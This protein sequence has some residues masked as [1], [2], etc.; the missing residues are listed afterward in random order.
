MPFVQP[1][2]RQVP[3]R[4][5]DRAAVG[6]VGDGAVVDL[7]DADL[8]E[9][10]D[11]GDGGLDVRGEPVEVFLEEL[12]FALLVGAV[13]VAAGRALLV[14][15]EDETAILFAHVPGR[16]GFA[17]HPHLR[18]ALAVALDD[19]R[20]R[21]GDDVLVLDRD[22]RDVETEHGARLAG[23]VAGRADDVVGGD[24]ALVG[25]DH[26]APV[27]GALEARHRG[28]AVDLGPQGAGTLGERLGEVGRLDVAVVRMLDRAEEAVRLAQRPDLL[29]L[30]RGEHV[31]VDADRLGDAG[32]GHELVPAVRR[33]GKTD[34]GDLLEADWLARLGLQRAVKLHRV[35]VDLAHRVAHVEERQEAGGVPGRARGQLLALDEDDVRPAL[36]GQVIERRHAHDAAADHHHARVRPHGELLSPGR[37][38]GVPILSKVPRSLPTRPPSLSPAGDAECPIDAKLGRCVRPRAAFP[39]TAS[40]RS[41][42]CSTW[43]SATPTRSRRRGRW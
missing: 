39:G 21:L 12:V 38:S 3:G 20:V 16:V 18:Q 6:G 11:P 36:L 15:A 8:A 9:G 14:G 42:R 24:V 5:D 31:H 35:L 10:R 19:G 23:E 4:P 25:A 30:R 33:A 41:A 34:V 37:R 7:L 13:D 28:H 26:P 22:D 1:D 17:Q 43:R 40:G 32:I 29:D 2:V 27:G